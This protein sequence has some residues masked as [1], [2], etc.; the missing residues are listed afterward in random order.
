[1]FRGKEVRIKRAE[2]AGVLQMRGQ[3]APFRGPPGASR[4][5][6]T[7]GVLQAEGTQANG[8]RKMADMPEEQQGGQRS[9][10]EELGGE[11][12]G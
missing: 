12:L 7:G 2:R 8:D 9:A 4:T 1:M 11:A 6:H 5:P 3:T 10:R